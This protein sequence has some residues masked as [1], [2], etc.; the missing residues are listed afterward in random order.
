MEKIVSR[1]LASFSKKGYHP[2]GLCPFEEVTEPM[3]SPM[4]AKHAM[5]IGARQIHLEHTLSQLTK[6]C[7]DEKR[8][9]NIY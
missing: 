7:V 8:K 5:I 1:R 2:P 3:L 9:K 4:I 6:F